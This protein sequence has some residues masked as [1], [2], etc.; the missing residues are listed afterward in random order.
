[1]ALV[2]GVGPVVGGG[3]VALAGGEVEPTAGAAVACP[4]GVVW[5][6]MTF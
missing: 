6:Y 5:L 2:E 3:E 1:V 4:V